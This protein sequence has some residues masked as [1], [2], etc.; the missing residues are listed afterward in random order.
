MFKL[1]QD[2]ELDQ[3]QAQPH[4]QQGD[5]HHFKHALGNRVF[6]NRIE[7]RLHI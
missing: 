5:T 1:G 7:R 4:A 6:C 2:Q 3:D